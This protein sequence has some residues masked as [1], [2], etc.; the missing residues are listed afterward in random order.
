MLRLNSSPAIRLCAVSCALLVAGCSGCRNI[1]QSTKKAEFFSMDTVVTLQA[2]GRQAQKALTEI[3]NS[4]QQLEQL[5]SKTLEVSELFRLNHAQDTLSVPLSDDT[6]AIIGRALDISQETDGAFDISLSKL[7]DLW[8]IGAENPEIPDI[9]E[10]ADALAQTGY[11]KISVQDGGVLLSGGCNL[12]LGG[13]AKGY[14]TDRAKE[15]LEKNG[16]ENALLSFGGN[17]YAKGTNNGDP[18][19]VGIGN[20][21]K[22]T[23][24][25]G[26]IE[27]SGKAVV[28]SGDYQRY[29]EKN[30]VR[31]HHII[32]PVTGSPAQ[33]GLRS[34]TIISD[35]ATLA[36]GYS[37]ALFVM[38]LP[39]AYEFASAHPEMEA[40]FVTDEKQVICTKGIQAQFTFRG[41]DDLFQYLPDYQPS[42][43]LGSSQ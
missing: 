20:P 35:D 42:D 36:D 38:G 5:F 21:E 34:V 3:E 8:D 10:I 16:V 37:T 6:L 43:G 1:E 27:T 12:D 7:T 23:K 2:S 19:K 33:S 13:I 9:G 40:I 17:V 39:K 18:W 32:D 15:I 30:G 25:L 22:T 31:Y 41:D 29:F 11:R 14:A 26:Y 24:I 4:T 28:T